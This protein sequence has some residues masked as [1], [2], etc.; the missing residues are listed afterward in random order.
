MNADPSGNTQVRSEAPLGITPPS[1][2]FSF[3]SFENN[4]LGGPGISSPGWV[5]SE[6]FPIGAD[7][8]LFN[9]TLLMDVVD[10]EAGRQWQAAQG[11]VRFALGG[12][13]A[14]LSQSYT[15]ARFNQGSLNFG[16]FA[17]GTFTDTALLTSRREF[18]GG[19]PTLAA[20][21]HRPLG[22]RLGVYA[23]TRLSL[24]MGE[25]DQRAAVLST[26]TGGIFI[27]N[28]NSTTFAAQTEE[29]FHF[30]PVVELEAGGEWTADRGRARFVVQAG[31]NFQSWFNAGTAAN[32]RGALFLFG[33][34]GAAGV[35]F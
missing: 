21:Y 13:F 35:R 31:I 10:L 15:A 8:L 7:A 14:R 23:S 33:M 18:N 17:S 20:E 27:F 9:S 5:M 22:S 29:R 6:P 2:P 32:D 4:N 24:L 19:G 12:R 34:S 1:G 28:F 11:T 30:L 26:V 25:E 3:G 16:Q